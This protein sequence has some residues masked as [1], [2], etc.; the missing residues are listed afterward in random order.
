MSV[1]SLIQTT[2]DDLGLS[3]E[4]A[5]AVHDLIA[6]LTTPDEAKSY[7]ALEGSYEETQE[8]L[9][10]AVQLY[11][12]EVYGERGEDNDWWCSIEG[13]F[14]DRVVVTFRFYGGD[15]R[16]NATLEFPY[17]ED[18]NGA[19]ELGEPTEVEVTA[20]VTPATGTPAPASTET[21]DEGEMNAEAKAILESLEG[22]EIKK[23]AVLSE[24]N[25]TALTSALE[26]IQKVL[27][28][29]K[30]EAAKEDEKGEKPEKRTVKP[31]GEKKPDP[32]AEGEKD[33]DKKDGDPDLETKAETVTA[34]ELLEMVALAST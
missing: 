2:V 31:K 34:G 33:P 3:E 7:P 14:E 30:R 22:L 9:R 25:A 21:E 18:E 6:T 1:K 17:T 8:S 19:I 4:K 32:K 16:E 10:N 13:T 20:T 29:A 26:A 11:G 12:V 23:G 15:G 28:A 27:A 5:K 24:A